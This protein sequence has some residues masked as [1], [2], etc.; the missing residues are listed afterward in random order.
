M[1]GLCVEGLQSTCQVQQ[2]CDHSNKR[3]LWNLDNDTHLLRNVGLDLCLGVAPPG[4]ARAAS[5]QPH[6][7]PLPNTVG[8]DL[9]SPVGEVYGAVTVVSSYV[10]HFVTAQGLKD[11][12]TATLSAIGVADVAGAGRLQPYWWT[13]HPLSDLPLPA[14]IAAGGNPLPLLQA[15]DWS[16]VQ[17]LIMVPEL[18]PGVFLLGETTKLVPVGEARFLRVAVNASTGAGA[19]QNACGVTVDLEGAPGEE[20]TVQYTTPESVS[21]PE[22]VTCTIGMGGGATLTL[23]DGTCTKP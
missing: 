22:S 7:L 5:Q 4:A 2:T 16:V 12:Y 15:K 11:D 10:W 13:G 23:P 3:Q 20:V 1:S 14:I 18:C 9:P 8:E 6:S 17:Y 19:H 21:R